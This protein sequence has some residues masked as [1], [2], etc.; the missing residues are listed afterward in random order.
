ML[1]HGM[2]AKGLPTCNLIGRHPRTARCELVRSLFYMGEPNRTEWCVD[3]CLPELTSD[4]KFAR[5]STNHFVGTNP[6]FRKT[7]ILTFLWLIL[8]MARAINKQYFSTIVTFRS[9]ILPSTID[10]NLVLEMWIKVTK[11]IRSMESHKIQKMIK[12]QFWPRLRDDEMPDKMT[13][14]IT[15]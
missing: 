14:I 7:D 1:F 8:G 5:S 15:R 9:I 10:Q 4:I 3:P 11:F 2:R 12:K 13:D 6:S